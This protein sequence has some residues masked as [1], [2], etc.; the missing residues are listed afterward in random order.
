MNGKVFICG[1]NTSKLPKLSN[2]ETTILIKEV[3]NGNLEAKQ[4]FIYANLRLVLSVIQ[5]FLYKK[6]DCSDDLFQ[7]GCV[8][9]IKAIDNFD[10]TI[11]IKFSTYAVPMIVGEIKRFLRDDFPLR[12]SRSLRDIAYQALQARQKIEAETQKEAELEEIAN[13]MNVPITQVACALDALSEPMSLDEPLF[14]DENDSSNLSDHIADS[15][16]TQEKWIDKV[17]IKDAL[18]SL[19][20][21]EQTILL[22]RYFSGKTQTEVSTQVGISQAQ[23]SR[24]EKSALKS[25]KKFLIW[26][27]I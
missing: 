17:S 13:Y 7:V 10:H 19:N 27:T 21:R 22:L 18:K 8:G 1:V 9:L 20:K 14:F 23:V 16:E 4:K 11:G 12:V 24:I 6:N 15:S 26:N 2:E 3:K 5:K 25:V